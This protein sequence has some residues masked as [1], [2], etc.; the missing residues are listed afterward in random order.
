[1]CK[2]CTFIHCFVL[3]VLFFTVSFTY[4]FTNNNS[5][6]NINNNKIINGHRYLKFF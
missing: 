1:M 3:V 2:T 6:N 5:I 4:I